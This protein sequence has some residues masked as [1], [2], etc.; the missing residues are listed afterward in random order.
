LKANKCEQLGG[1]DAAMAPFAPPPPPA[2]ARSGAAGVQASLVP[3]S[4]SKNQFF[5]KKSQKF[6]LIFKTIK[7]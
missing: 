6:E 1:L 3:A 4:V 7:N 5:E 2:S